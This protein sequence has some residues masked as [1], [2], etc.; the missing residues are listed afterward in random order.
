[1]N[2]GEF[3]ELDRK[4]VGTSKRITIPLGEALLMRQVADILR[5][6]A[7]QLDFNSRRTDLQERTRRMQDRFDVDCANRKIKDAAKLFGTEI[8]EGRRTNAE[9]LEQEENDTGTVTIRAIS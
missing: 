8:R 3:T 2:D 7:T 5:G 1:M 6:L 9:R 4:I